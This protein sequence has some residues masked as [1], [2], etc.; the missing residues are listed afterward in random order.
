MLSLFVVAWT[1]AA[2]NGATWTSGEYRYDGGVHGHD[3]IIENDEGG[4]ITRWNDQ[5]GKETKKKVKEG[6]WRRK[7]KDAD[8]PEIE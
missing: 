3:V 4:L 5:T 1:A 6:K 8:E 7:P 2:T